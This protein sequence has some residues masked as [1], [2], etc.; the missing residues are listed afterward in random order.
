MPRETRLFHFKN[1]V[2][3]ISQLFFQMDL[4]WVQFNHLLIKFYSK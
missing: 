3:I 2:L 4:D 1:W